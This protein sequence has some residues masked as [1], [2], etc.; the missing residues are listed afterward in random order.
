MDLL[1]KNHW[2]KLKASQQ[3]TNTKVEHPAVCCQPRQYISETN[4]NIRLWFKFNHL[5]QISCAKKR[6]Q[7]SI[8]AVVPPL[9]TLCDIR[10]D[11][12]QIPFLGNSKIVE[13]SE[14]SLLTRTD[15]SAKCRPPGL[16]IRNAPAT[17][18]QRNCNC[19]ID[20]WHPRKDWN[21]KESNQIQ[22]RT[23]WRILHRSNLQQ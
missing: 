13:Q 1:P 3:S 2:H 16:P 9:K 18:S 21:A 17:T 10:N 15:G 11:I 23:A 14:V 22:N 5:C 8:M 12:F 20:A 7:Q 19:Y 4:E 6:W